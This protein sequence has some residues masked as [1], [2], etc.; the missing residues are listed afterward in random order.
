[1][2]ISVCDVPFNFAR[3][4]MLE[5]ASVKSNVSSRDRA[6]VH[7]L[8]SG[9]KVSRP[10]SQFISCSTLRW[11][12]P[13]CATSSSQ[14]A[15]GLL[16][17]WSWEHVGSYLWIGHIFGAVYPVYSCQFGYLIEARVQW[18][19]SKKL[20]LPLKGRKWEAT[21]TLRNATRRTWTL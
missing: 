10:I 17:N 21:V 9:L 19:G 6:Y 18:H 1:M 8:I 3:N 2:N 12:V 20:S 5:P 4:W 16:L 15:R 7:H 14:V 13:A 11:P